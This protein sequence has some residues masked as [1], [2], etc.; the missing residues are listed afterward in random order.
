MKKRIIIACL[1]VIAAALLWF[2]IL[3]RTFLLVSTDTGVFTLYKNGVQVIHQHKNGIVYLDKGSYTVSPIKNN[4]PTTATYIQTTIF[5]WQSITVNSPSAS[6]TLQPQLLIGRN[7]ALVTPLGEGYIYKNT[8]TRGIE[9]AD[10]NGIKDVSSSFGIVSKSISDS[11]STY[12]TLVNI[13]HDGS[14][15][16]VTTTRGIY[17]LSSLATIEK[18]EFPDFLITRSSLDTK[19]QK[20]MFI[21]FTGNGTYS[22][23]SLPT[24]NL[25]APIQQ[26][27]TGSTLINSIVSGGNTALV[28]DDNIPNP[29]N[30]TAIAYTSKKQVTP[31]LINLTTLQPSA[32]PQLPNTALTSAAID[33]SGVYLAYRTKMSDHITIITISDGATVATVPATTLTQ[34][35]WRGETLVFNYGTLLLTYKPVD[36]ITSVMMTTPS[37]ITGFSFKDSTPIVST[38]QKFTFIGQQT[39][40]DVNTSAITLAKSSEKYDLSFSNVGGVLHIYRLCVNYDRCEPG[41]A[42]NSTLKELSKLGNTTNA[43][44]NVT[45]DF[46]VGDYS[47]AA[48]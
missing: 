39:V 42:Y 40:S 43:L 30:S 35:Q 20:I 48:Q 9:Y 22:A 19:A 3:T 32:I 15:V 23:Y 24:V 31:Q 2:F 11:T 12:N 28:Y 6:P 38:N 13:D 7:A 8:T 4:T 47:Y 16:F 37:I 17:K 21:T 27:Y 36:K 1:V 41:D 26:I 45:N 46:T 34:L 33:Q 18:T 29:S 14:T 25:S 10:K 44:Q 5:P